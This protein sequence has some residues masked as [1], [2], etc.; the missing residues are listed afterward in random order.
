MVCINVEIMKHATL[1]MQCNGAYEYSLV[2]FE[3]MT[4]SGCYCI[5]VDAAL[6][7]L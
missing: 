6:A 3:N 5:E 7:R 2:L 4:N 1:K